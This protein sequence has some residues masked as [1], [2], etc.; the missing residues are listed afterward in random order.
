MPK[1]KPNETEQEF[2]N[3]CIP[4]VEDEG[5][6]HDQAVAQ[7]I[8][9]WEN[10]RKDMKNKIH[11]IYKGEVKS[12][13]DEDLT[14]EHF[15][16]TE[17]ED[18]SK[19]TVL[20]EGIK[21]DSTPVVLKQHGFDPDTGN[22]PIAKPLSISVS[23]NDS[24]VKGIKVKTKYYD[25]GHLTPPDNTGRRLY[26]KAKENYMPY[27]SIGFRII[28]GQPKKTGGI[29]IKECVV[30]EYSQVGVPD[31]VG[32]TTIKSMN[33]EQLMDKANELLVFEFKN[34]N[35]TKGNPD[36]G[37]S[38]KYCKCDACGYTEDH[39]AG[40]P[41]GNCPECGEQMHGT[42]DKKKKNLPKGVHIDH[43]NNGNA[44]S[45]V[46]SENNVANIL[47]N[48]DVITTSDIITD[49]HIDLIKEYFSVPE[50]KLKSIAERV[51][52]DIPL[53][54]MFT[55]WWAMVDELYTCDGKEK[56]V[57][58]ILKEF[59]ELIFPYMLDF[60]S[61]IEASNPDTIGIK[62]MIDDNINREMYIT[63]KGNNAEPAPYSHGGKQSQPDNELIKALLG[64][65]EELNKNK[66]IKS[67]FSFSREELADA[68]KSTV[69]GEVKKQFD[70][71]RG[72][73]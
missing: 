9:I 60:A 22:E 29:L 61:T 5:K 51:S 68:V 52:Q 30:F 46:D 63:D 35:K 21:F 32:A 55:L 24:G 13:N 27:W 48:K 67:A 43:T 69:S 20:A 2:M 56:T 16:S 73:L 4:T 18:R 11:K 70:V 14:I 53:N 12:F 57:K 7:C 10:R 44:Y 8:S 42:N 31:N 47:F 34:E 1:P 54:S 41:C 38:W 50:T 17:Q 23:T 71:M 6:P 49:E 37:G 19:D 62:R 36:E 58:A 3:R 40:K 15:I 59:T 33:H 65:K 25:G 66:Q 39:N 28:D 64:L 26:E 45:V 72:K